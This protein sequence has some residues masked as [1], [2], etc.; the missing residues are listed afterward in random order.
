M[1]FKDENIHFRGTTLIQENLHFV[2]YKVNKKIM[3]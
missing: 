2:F 1:L 3:F